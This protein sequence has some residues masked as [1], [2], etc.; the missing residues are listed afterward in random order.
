MRR[1]AAV[2]TACTLSA[3]AAAGLGAPGPGLRGHASRL[4]PVATGIG[5]AVGEEQLT[6]V[7]HSRTI[8]AP[9]QPPRPRTLTTIIRYPAQGAASRVDVRSATPARNAGPFPLV[10]FGHGFAVTPAGYFRLLRAWAR[11]GYV[12]A[13]PVFPLGNAHAPGGPDESDLVNQP[14]DMS[15]VISRM[16]AINTASH[17]LLHDMIAPGRVAVSGQ[18]DGGET[19]L[20]VAYDRFY[21][22]P[23]VRAAIILSGAQIP[24]GG[25]LMPGPPLLAV[26]GTADTVN[27]PR[28]TYEFFGVAHRP[29]FLLRLIGA[30]HLSP[31]T[32]Q[33]PQLTVVERVSIAFLD[34]YLKGARDG[35]ER[36][37]AAADPASVARLQAVP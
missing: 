10:V 15:V 19:A 25:S 6:F 24:G 4:A 36:M 32:D 35:L 18:S 28:N 37:R 29:K 21:R 8:A 23:R 2:A 22:D 27:A 11:A 16:L 12:V 26:Q 31:Y 7:D 34:R 14:R 13:A 9:G 1:A 17:A 20:A 3:L 30:A 5:F 33:Q